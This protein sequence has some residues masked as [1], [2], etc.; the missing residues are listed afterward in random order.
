MAGGASD[1]LQT[2]TAEQ[3]R[4]TIAAS[5]LTHQE[6]A[7]QVGCG[8]SQMWKYQKEGLPPRMNRQVRA[9]ILELAAQAGVLPQNARVRAHV[10]KLSKN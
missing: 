3:V 9:N 1:E 2:L 4:T 8:S 6:F 10:K 5:G 7:A